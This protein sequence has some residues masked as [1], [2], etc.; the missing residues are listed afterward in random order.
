MGLSSNLRGTLEPLVFGLMSIPKVALYPVVLLLFG[1]GLSAK[2]CF[3]LMH[4]LP[5][6]ALMVMGV[7]RNVRPI[8]LRVG[9]SLNL[10]RPTLIFHVMLPYAAPEII[11]GVQFAFSITLQGV[12]LGELFASKEGLG[13]LLINAIGIGDAKTAIGLTLLL[14]VLVIGANVMLLKLSRAYRGP[15]AAAK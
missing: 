2:V 14:T 15:G 11:S 10:S 3:G 13:F 5:V 4:G 8:Y 9:K 1:L 12:I 7:I 6:L